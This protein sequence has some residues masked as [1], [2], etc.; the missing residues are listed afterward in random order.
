MESKNYLIFI[1]VGFL[2]NF[3][4][5]LIQTIIKVPI[6]ILSRTVNIIIG[7]WTAISLVNYYKPYVTKHNIMKKNYFIKRIIIHNIIEE[8]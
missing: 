8:K 3:F 6:I 1:V 5:E 2:F 7:I 4:C